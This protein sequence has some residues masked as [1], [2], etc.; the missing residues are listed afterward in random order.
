MEID[1]TIVRPT[2]QLD[3]YYPAFLEMGGNTGTSV[4]LPHG[5]IRSESVT[6]VQ[7]PSYT[8][9]RNSDCFT[10]YLIYTMP[11]LTDPSVRY[12]KFVPEPYPQ[13]T[14]PEKECRKAPIWLSTDLR[15]GNQ[16]LANRKASFSSTH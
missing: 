13:R 3:L 15:D 11:M 5:I 12:S 1:T 6:K 2:L 8:S 14:W 16:S 7:L 9:T 4:A 10:L